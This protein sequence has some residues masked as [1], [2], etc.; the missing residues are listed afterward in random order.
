MALRLGGLPATGGPAFNF[1]RKGHNGDSTMKAFIAALI[2]A[3]YLFGV[4]GCN[5]I[6]GAGQDVKA[7]GAKVEG[8]AKEHK[9]Y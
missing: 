4:T 1:P 3:A 7:A 2:G 6:E 9:R 8:E 5:T